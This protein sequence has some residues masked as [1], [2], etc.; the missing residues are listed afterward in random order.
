MPIKVGLI[1]Q[2][3]MYNNMEVVQQLTIFQNHKNTKSKIV[4]GQLFNNN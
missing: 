1:L 3:T 2:A 4:R